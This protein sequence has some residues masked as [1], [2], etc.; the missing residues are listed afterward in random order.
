MKTS[1]KALI[2]KFHEIVKDQ[3]DNQEKH[4]NAHTEKEFHDIGT[5]VCKLLGVA[6]EL[7]LLLNDFVGKVMDHDKQ[8]KEY[9]DYK[10]GGKP[11]KSSSLDSLLNKVRPNKKQVVQWF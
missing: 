7:N 2:E 1:Q 10:Q 5:F 4:K 6:H 9:H 11:V 3:K 8:T